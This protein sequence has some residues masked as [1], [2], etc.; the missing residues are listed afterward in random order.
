MWSPFPIPGGYSSKDVFREL[1]SHSDY[2]GFIQYGGLPLSHDEYNSRSTEED[3][4]MLAFFDSLIQR[5]KDSFHSDSDDSVWDDFH[6]SIILQARSSEGSD[7][8]TMGTSVNRLL[9]RESLHRPGQGS[10]DREAGANSSGQ[11]VLRRLRHLR[12]AAVIRDLLNADSS[13]SDEETTLNELPRDLDSAHNSAHPSVTFKRYRRKTNRRYR[14]HTCLRAENARSSSSHAVND[15]SSTESDDKRIEAKTGK[16][17]CYAE[18]DSSSS[19]VTE[20][21]TENMDSGSDED[22]HRNVLQERTLLHA[23][24]GQSSADVTVCKGREQH[25]DGCGSN[26]RANGTTQTTLN[27]KNERSAIPRTDFPTSCSSS[28]HV[29]AESSEHSPA[30]KKCTLFTEE[31]QP[32]LEDELQ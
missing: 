30:S 11:G 8:D 27:H 32:L 3:P 28:Q 24:N 15:S 20:G 12:N 22:E 7:S 25:T 10:P 16:D 6:L 21:S 1:Y 4:R 13:S 17:T 18:E 14:F 23:I 31:K 26:D 29:D 9:A 2:L 19:S 5:E